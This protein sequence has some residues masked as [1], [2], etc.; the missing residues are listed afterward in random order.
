MIKI[1]E[2]S[3]KTAKAVAGITKQGA[4]EELRADSSDV[5]EN[6]EISSDGK[7]QRRGFAS[8]NGQLVSFPYKWIS[9]RY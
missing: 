3:V 2:K 9:L 7:W 6:V 1:I 8:L 4:C 5:A